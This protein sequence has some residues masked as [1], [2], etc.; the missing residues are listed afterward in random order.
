MFNLGQLQA[1]S[2]CISLPPSHQAERP[3]VP[4]SAI[5]STSKLF[6]FSAETRPG[7]TP[8]SLP[9]HPRSAA[10]QGSPGN[11][12]FVDL[13]LLFALELGANLMGYLVVVAALHGI[14][15]AHPITSHPSVRVASAEEHGVYAVSCRKNSCEDGF[16]YNHMKS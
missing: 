4:P 3:R 11:C 1:P 5:C 14:E 13:G 16:P 12:V 6:M 9:A 2:W 15:P 7:C 10:Q 8:Q